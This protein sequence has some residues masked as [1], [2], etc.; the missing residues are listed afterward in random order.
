MSRLKYYR[1]SCMTISQTFV[2]SIVSGCFK[3]RSRLHSKY[4]SPL[5]FTPNRSSQVFYSFSRRTFEAQLQV[6]CPFFPR[7]ICSFTQYVLTPLLYCKHPTFQLFLPLPFTLNPS[8]KLFLHLVLTRIFSLFLPLS[9]TLNY[10]VPCLKCFYLLFTWNLISK[11]FLH[12]FLIRVGFT[13][14][15]PEVLQVV[16]TLF[17]YPEPSLQNFKSFSWL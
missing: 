17:F 5:S 11:F 2:R 7:T 3:P 12:F 15:H 10:L 1:T 14:L 4:F 6:V 9:S 13:F 8:F 16:F